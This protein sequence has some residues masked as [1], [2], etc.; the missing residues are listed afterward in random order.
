[1]YGVFGDPP[2]LGARRGDR[3]IDIAALGPLDGVPEE[4]LAAPVL[5][6]LLEAGPAVWAALDAALEGVEGTIAVGEVEPVLPIAVADYVDFY[7]SLHHA[8]NVGRMFRPDA[9]PLPRNWRHLPVGYHGRSGTVVVSGTPV[10][11]PRG[12]LPGA[13]GPRFGPTERLDFELELGAVIGVPSSGPVAVERALEH[14]FGLVLLN[15]WSARDIQ[16]WEY[17]P[18]GP[19]LAKSFATSIGAWITPLA[20]AARLPRARRAAGAAA[21]GL[22]ARGPVGVR[23]RPRGRAPTAPSITRSSGRHLYWSLAQQIAHLTSNGATLRA[24]DLLGSGTVSG[25]EPHERG[26]LLERAGTA[27]SR[28]AWPTAASAR[29]CGTATRSCC[30]GRASP[31]S[32][33]GSGPE[34]ATSPRAATR[35]ASRRARSS[36]VESAMSISTVWPRLLSTSTSPMRWNSASIA[37]LSVNSVATK[38]S[39]PC[40]RARATSRVEQEAAE[41]AAL[42]GVDHHDRR[43]GREAVVRGSACSGRPPG[44]R[45]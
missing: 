29:G 23:P 24:G 8:T 5:N 39:M 3:V 14:V 30:A 13:D 33:A 9:D 43:L 7:S 28:C 22:P 15:D 19:F 37:R 4:V 41:A 12:Q 36:S 45:R 26:C 34:P 1:M 2:R 11:R 35:S 21:A 17:Q 40:S 20:D 25:P 10:R 18:L 42:P 38:R 27:P 16:A 32:Q 6:P 44:P 31:R